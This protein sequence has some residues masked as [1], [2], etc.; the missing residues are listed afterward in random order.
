M[1]WRL[2]PWFSETL[3][4]T[5]LA[6]ITVVHQQMPLLIGSLAIQTGSF[7]YDLVTTIAGDGNVVASGG[8]ELDSLFLRFGIS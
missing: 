8:A 6:F 3:L 2:N 7:G 1:H 5:V 4:H